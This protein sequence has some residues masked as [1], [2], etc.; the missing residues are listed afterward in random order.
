MGSLED[1]ANERARLLRK[2]NNEWH[3]ALTAKYKQMQKDGT[4]LKE[5]AGLKKGLTPQGGG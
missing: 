1:E 5:G 2:E 3:R 4:R